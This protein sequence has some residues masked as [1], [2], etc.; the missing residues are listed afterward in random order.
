MMS[1]CLAWIV[2]GMALTLSFWG[3]LRRLD[4]PPDPE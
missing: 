1:V 2:V 4:L 3:A